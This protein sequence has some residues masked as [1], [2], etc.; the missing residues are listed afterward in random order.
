MAETLQ[1]GSASRN[2]HRQSVVTEGVRRRLGLHSIATAHKVELTA[3]KQV[4]AILESCMA[5]GQ[6]VRAEQLLQRFARIVHPEIPDSE[7]DLLAIEAQRADVV[8]DLL[9]HEYRVTRSPDTRRRWLRARRAEAELNGR[10]TRA[11]EGGR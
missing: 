3:P 5:H 2:S 1:A 11:L 6:R 8:E 10:Y 7:T 4:E 9:E